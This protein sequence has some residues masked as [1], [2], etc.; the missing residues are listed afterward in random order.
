MYDRVKHGWII[1]TSIIVFLLSCM[2]IQYAYA[3]ATVGDVTQPTPKY[4]I[5]VT[6]TTE[7]GTPVDKLKY[8]A[9]LFDDLVSCQNAIKNDP[10]FKASLGPLATYLVEKAIV[11]LSGS[12]SFACEP[13]LETAPD[14][15]I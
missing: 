1:P 11:P 15:S 7:Q 12:L 4:K 10:E 8:R 14:D 2:F 5:T 3:E 13:A 6:V 9:K